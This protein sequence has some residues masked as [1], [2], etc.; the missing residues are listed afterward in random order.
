VLFHQ[1][2][3]LVAAQAAQSQVTPFVGG[4]GFGQ[5]FPAGKDDPGVGGEF[6][7]AGEEI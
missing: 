2:D 5:R 6:Q 7:Q 1:F 4:K 3:R